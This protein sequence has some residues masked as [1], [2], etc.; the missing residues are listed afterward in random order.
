MKTLVL[1][2]L[3]VS[4]GF[5]IARG[6]SSPPRTPARATELTAAPSDSAAGG[7]SPATP[8]AKTRPVHIPRFE[9]APVIDGRLDEEVWKRAAVLKDFYQIEPGDNIAPS[10]ETEVLLGYDDKCFFVAFR[11]YDEPEKVRAT[12]AKRDSLG[13]EDTVG[14]YLD[15]FNDQRKA[16]AIFL[17]PFGVQADAVLTEG[18]DEDFSVDIVMES[19]GVITK[20]GYTVELALPF[21]SLR[22]EAGEGRLWGA[23]FLRRIKR[24]NNER[25][26]W[27]P[28]SRDA[29]GFLS[30][31]G[32]IGGLEGVSAGRTL[33][34]IPSLTL[35]EAGARVRPAD[36]GATGSVP[37]RA[38]GFVNR[39][40]EVDPGVTVKLGFTP[41]TTLALT[42]NPDFA[43]VE[44]D[45]T[46]VTA[47]Q[48][49]PIFFE[50]KR[51]FFLEGIEIFRTRLNVVNTRAIVDPDYA[52]KLTGKRGRNTFGLLAASDNAPGNYSEEERGDP[53][54]RPSIER[55]LDKN[56]FVGVVRL[57]R[58]VGSESSIGLLATTYNFVDKHNHVGGVDGR[59]RLGPRTVFE[60]QVL[61]TTTRGIFFDPN[62]FREVYR[63]GNALGY[64][65]R[66]AYE[67]RHFGYQFAGEGRT[68]D[69]RA[70]AGFTRRA[71]SNSENI[72]LRYDSKPRPKSTLIS[73]RVSN[74]SNANFDWRGRSQGWENETQLSLSFRRQTSLALG[75][76]GG[77]ERVFEN[78]F[79][80]NCS[81]TCG[82][83]FAGADS[84]RSTYK[85]NFFA[86]AVT[87]PSK[88]YSVGVSL[89]KGGGALDFDFGAGPR[90]PRVSP[91]ALLDPGAPQ[92]PGPGDTLDVGLSLS[93]Q[94]TDA[95]HTSFDYTK[96]RL[97][98]RDTGRT[99]FDENIFALRW[100]YQFTRFVFAR[101]RLDYDAL[102]SNVRG[103]FLFGWAPNPGTSFFVGYNDDLNHNGFNPFTGG[104]EPGFRRNGR[105][106]FIKTSYLFRRGL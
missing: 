18:V 63:T 64:S 71:D 58:D 95:L 86:T 53:T 11:A 97:V 79:A 50:E 1:T 13:A 66:Y 78:E 99:A 21:N 10:K 94:P 88:K 2:L 91:A 83:G 92:D 74:Y 39:N 104:F 69:Y 70:D 89:N 102:A 75:F 77:Y 56:A 34:V 3:A 67:G 101:V 20:E 93:F 32:H 12:M 27:M 103:Q 35:S 43:Q 41:T 24:R 36:G 51:P 30:Q 76:N 42:Y 9:Q 44:A 37:A 61:G 57:K 26:S 33:E 46:V 16:Y 68:R 48:R 31:A 19:A 62:S 90:F 65:M 80:A 15:T 55:F 4:F 85:R 28:I 100:T 40:I 84:E 47:N 25:S 14:M 59:F 8:P 45:Q 73:Y 22:Y 17:N 60:F 106:F 29:S 87:A 5:L 38:Y 54:A 23:H 96:S 49:F 98:R 81:P 6:Q 7:P 72:F 105:T 52:V 82:V